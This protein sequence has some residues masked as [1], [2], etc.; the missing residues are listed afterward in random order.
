MIYTNKQYKTKKALRADFTAGKMITVFQ[1]GPFG[2]SVSDGFG[3]VAGPQFPLAHKWYAAVEV[4][5]G[6][7]VAVKK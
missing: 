5:N 7:I 2:T 6:Q 4:K 3:V 1:P